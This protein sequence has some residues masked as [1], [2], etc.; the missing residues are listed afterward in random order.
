M[1]RI[2][3]LT[4]DTFLNICTLYSKRMQSCGF[5]ANTSLLKLAIH[6]KY[7]SHKVASVN[8]PQQGKVTK[9]I[10]EK[11]TLVYKSRIF[12]NCEY[13]PQYVQRNAGT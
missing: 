11:A 1:R 2:Y 9:Y 12:W 6:P 4:A 7:T 10:L 3:Q 5:L 8:T 13:E